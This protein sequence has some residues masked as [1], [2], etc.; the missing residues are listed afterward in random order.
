MTSFRTRLDQHRSLRAHRRSDRA[1][2]RAMAAA[3]TLDSVH[4]IATLAARR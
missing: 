4:E 3:P 2:S 1:L